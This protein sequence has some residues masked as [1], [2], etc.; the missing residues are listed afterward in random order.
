M[1]VRDLVIVESPT[2]AKTISRFLQGEYTIESSQGHIRDLP[3]KDD[4]AVDVANG[5]TPR[6][7]IVRGKEKIVKRLQE[8]AQQASTVWLATDEDREGEAIAWHLAEALQL[9]PAK[10][11]RIV[12]HEITRSAIERALKSPRGI[13]YNLVNAQQARRILDRLVG[14]ELSPILWRKVRS[15]KSAGRVQSVAVRLIVEREREIEA[16]EPTIAFRIRGR[17]RTGDGELVRAELSERLSD[18]D[19]VRHL[20]EQLRLATYS[21]EDLQTKPGKKSPPAPFTTSTLQQEASR[22]LGLPI[23]KTMQLAQQLYESGYIT[24]MRT[25]SVTLSDEALEAAAALIS[26]QFGEK[27]HQRRQYQT[28]VANAQEAHEAIRPTDLTRRHIDIRD[29]Q[30]QRLY[31]LIW[32]RTLASQMSE[33]QLERTIATIAP[34]TTDARFVAEGEVIVFDG[35]LRLENEDR[36]EETDNEDADNTVLPPLS[37]GQQLEV[38]QI[39]AR[40]TFSRPP[41]RYTEATLVRRLEELGIGRPSTYATIIARIQERGYVERKSKEGSPRSVHV[42]RLENGVVT[43]ATETEVV[44]SEKNKLFPTP[45]GMLVTDFLLEHFPDVMDYQFTASVEEQ[46]DE[47]ARG[48]RQWQQM[49]D[50]FYK[51]FHAKVEQVLQSAAKVGRRLLG[52]DPTTG[53]EITAGISRT[54]Q[55]YIKRGDQF[56]SVPEG[57]SLDEL[58]LED[59]LRYLQFP[60]VLGEH[61]GGTVTVA[62]GR[63]AYVE[64]RSTRNA[65]ER[66]FAN[67]P[68]EL[69]PLTLTL[70]TAIELLE[71]ANQERAEMAERNQPRVLGTTSDGREVSV[72]VGRFGPYVRIGDEF[73]SIPRDRMQTLTVEEALELLSQKHQERDQ[74]ILRRFEENPNAFVIQGK[75]K[76]YLQVGKRRYWLPD[77][78]DYQHASLD[79][80]LAHAT[81]AT[82]RRTSPTRR[83]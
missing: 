65:N 19:Q 37:V 63:G 18:A 17:F 12:F 9:D 29:A 26:S 80:C 42:V 45:I 43:E 69:D 3:E 35:F 41:A 52:T 6:Y 39:L 70:D 49:L 10:T 83:K 73:V 58:T 22:R 21:I 20:F 8:L 33:A 23:A 5:Y 64:W 76:P 68:Q 11:R 60:R 27:Y 71:R 59:A 28:K 30:A 36:T 15:A 81:P 48:E 2:K 54:Q 79:D 50:E 4:R 55:L 72:G 34:S 66:R 38:E 82:Q 46:F 1:P 14:Y 75:S 40:Q 44:G 47:I 61:N 24:Y 53:E 57:I 62:L 32:K 16:F 78:F 74:R 7:V 31:E 56:A 25:D 67:V 13:D 51:P 77:A